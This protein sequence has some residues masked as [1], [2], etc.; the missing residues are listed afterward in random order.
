MFYFPEVLK[1]RGKFATIWLA[2]TKA[3]KLSRREYIQ[4]NVNRSCSD[5]LEH[6]T[7]RVRPRFALYLSAQLMYGVV[8]IFN[9]QC[10]FLADDIRS[11]LERLFQSSRSLQIDLDD[12][13][14]SS[15]TI[16]DMLTIMEQTLGA[17]DPW[18]GVMSFKPGYPLPSMLPKCSLEI[19]APDESEEIMARSPSAVSITMRPV[20]GIS[21]EELMEQADLPEMTMREIEALLSP[22]LVAPFVPSKPERGKDLGVLQEEDEEDV[23]LEKV[24]LEEKGLL[25]SILSEQDWGFPQEEISAVPTAAAVPSPALEPSVAEIPKARTIPSPPS[26]SPSHPPLPPPLG[27]VLHDVIAD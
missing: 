13:Q 18:F 8:F 23:T 16:P 26:L 14:K 9:K 24:R 20:E 3:V 2:A 6:I 17:P 27:P 12:R 22:H 1:K 7:L 4:V 25:E 10:A 5:I 19:I 15:F 21:K 11:H